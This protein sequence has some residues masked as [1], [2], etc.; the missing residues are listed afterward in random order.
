MTRMLTQTCATLLLALTLLFPLAAA[1]Q[2]KAPA[3]TEDLQKL[4]STLENDGDRQK[5]V[6]QLKTLLAAQHQGA[7]EEDSGV[8]AVVSDRLEALGDDLM[9]AVGALRDLPRLA[10][11]A[12]QQASDPALRGRW[13]DTAGRLLALLAAAIAADQILRRLLRRAEG[14]TQP[15]EAAPPLLLVRLPL[16]LARALLRTLPVGAAIAAAWGMAGFLGLGGNLRV[17]GVMLVTAY[18]SVRLLMVLARLVAAPRTAS[19]RLLP[20]DDETAEYLVIWSRR[21]A[22]TAMFGGLLVQSMLLLGLPRGAGAMAFKALGLSI[23]TMLVIFILQNR[24]SVAA[25]LRGGVGAG[26]LQVVRAR[27]AEVW[28][29][30]AVLYVVAGYAVWALKVKGGFDFMLRASVLSVAILVV[31]GMLSATLGRMIER[32]FAVSQ[33]VRD[34]FPLLEARANRYLPMLHVVLRGVVAVMTVLALAQA[35]GLDTLGLLASDGGRRVVSALVSIAAVLLGALVVWEIVS[36]AIERYL[37]A[38]DGDGNA[39]ARSSRIRTLLPLAR[40]AL[41]VVLV[42]MVSLIV[43]SELGVNIAPLLA[44]AGVVGVAVGFGSQTLVKDVITG[45][46]ILFEDTMA[47]GDVVSLGGHSGVVEA[48]SI[49]TIRLRD[50]SGAVH[51]IPFSSV[52]D[53]VNMT[54]DFSCAVFEVGVAYREDTDAVTETLAQLGSELQADAVYGPLILEPLEIA[55]LDRLDA[56]SVVIK[57]RFKTLPAKQWSVM[58]EFNRRMKQRFDQLGI[59]IPFP[60]TTL[61]FGQDKTGTAPPA[62]VVQGS[63]NA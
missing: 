2:D 37:A 17:A 52:S 9:D 43:L 62:R 23:A 4:V 34:S 39:L 40:N 11:W 41:F 10:A 60:Q 42:V 21:L 19:L 61:W 49:R 26:R 12:G 18:A 38:T 45:A 63:S 29:I 53:V 48:M 47:V 54:K 28:H 20:V 24:Q 31:A 33:D 46:F 30:L 44:G 32:G 5:L 15:R 22:G 50:F 51:T 36:G 35:W 1:A 7:A 8:L 14:V 55:G 25:A 59:E 3:R 57:A 16:G 58:R 13:L 56:S 6:G 27:L